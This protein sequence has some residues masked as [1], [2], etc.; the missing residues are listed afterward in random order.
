MDIIPLIAFNT[1]GFAT[2]NKENCLPNRTPITRPNRF[3]HLASSGGS[4]TSIR[5]DIRRQQRLPDS[6]NAHNPAAQPRTTI[7][8]ALSI[9]YICSTR[10]TCNRPAVPTIRLWSRRPGI[11]RRKVACDSS[12][13]C[14]RKS[15]H[16]IRLCRAPNHKPI[17]IPIGESFARLD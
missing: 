16:W 4:W 15:G 13:R 6:R 9:R 7:R 14:K 3:R 8:P 11:R 5:S 2:S 12:R 17:P 1:H 10:R